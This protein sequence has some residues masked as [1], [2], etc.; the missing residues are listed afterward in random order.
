MFSI[1][2]VFALMSK[3]NRLGYRRQQF[4]FQLQNAP[5]E[6][7]MC[8]L[9]GKRTG[10][11]YKRS[12]RIAGHAVRANCVRS[13]LAVNKNAGCP[14]TKKIPEPITVPM[15]SKIRSRRLRTRRSSRL[16][17][18]GRDWNWVWL[19]RESRIRHSLDSL[20]ASSS[21]GHAT[22]L[23]PSFRSGVPLRIRVDR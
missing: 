9:Q 1:L 20:S 13:S 18:A 7:Q 6:P 12:P 4:Q 2:P 22:P 19:A 23:R 11:E 3:P 17:V 14:G 16:G 5:A 8:S 21:R 15:T 10:D